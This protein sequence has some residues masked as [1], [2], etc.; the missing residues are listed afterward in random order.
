MASTTRSFEERGKKDREGEMT[1]IRARQARGYKE[2]SK[3]RQHI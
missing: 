1:K 3:D 2:G